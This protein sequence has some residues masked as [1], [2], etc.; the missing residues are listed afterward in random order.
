MP[1][2]MKILVLYR[3]ELQITRMLPGN[4]NDGQYTIS[5]QIGQNNC[6]WNS[7]LPKI[8]FLFFAEA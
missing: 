5:A 2:F 1:F 4:P 3:Q 8:G 7:F 6:T